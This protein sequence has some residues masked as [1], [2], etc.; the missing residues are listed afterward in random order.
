ME[1]TFGNLSPP[2]NNVNPVPDIIVPDLPDN[3]PQETI[4]IMNNLND[5]RNELVRQLTYNMWLMDEKT[6][7]CDA[8]ILSFHH[9]QDEDR[10]TAVET[11]IASLLAFKKSVIGLTGE[12]D[13]QFENRMD[14]L[15]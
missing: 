14:G 8:I 7:R 3:A 6:R 2:P 12:T 13:M 15:Y 10:K 9:L 1:L 11:S 4:A 5:F